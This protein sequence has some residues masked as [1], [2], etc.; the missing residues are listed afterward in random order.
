MTESNQLQSGD[1]WL[2]HA[3]AE[4][5]FIENQGDR[6]HLLYRFDAQYLPALM[7]ANA[8]SE[9]WQVWEAFRYFITA[10]PTKRKTFA[11]T[12]DEADKVIDIL[13]K[14]VGLPRGEP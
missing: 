13:A 8:P 9:I 3:D 2:E 4:L 11:L 12:E 14:L 6:D 5:G 7:R 1:D 10:R